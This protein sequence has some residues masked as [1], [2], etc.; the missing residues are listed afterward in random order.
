MPRGN[1]S[2]KLA[3]SVDPEVHAGILAAAADSGLSVSAWMTSAARR[4]LLIHDGL[5]AVSEWEDENAPLT[6]REMELARQRV[7]KEL[8]ASAPRRSA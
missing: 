3:I 5:K 6:D 7:A 4:A 2:P 8:G 1:P